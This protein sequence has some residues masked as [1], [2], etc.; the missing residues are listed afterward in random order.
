V[1]VRRNTKGKLFLA[2][3]Q[4]RVFLSVT[5]FLSAITEHQGQEGNRE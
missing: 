2:L 1:N 5:R 4:K 3:L